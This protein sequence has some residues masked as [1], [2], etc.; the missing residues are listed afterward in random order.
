MT[1][2]RFDPYLMQVGFTLLE[3]LVAMMLFSAV[4]IGLAKGFILQLKSNSNSE[5]RSQAIQ[6]AQVVLDR[7]RTQDPATFPTSGQGASES[8]AVAGRNYTVS[9]RYCVKAA[10]CP[11]STTRHLRA[12][13]NYR[14]AKRYEVDT[15]FT[16]LR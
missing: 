3:V 10:F 12:T 9:V 13:V 16:Q 5:I 15:V 6:A 1:R 8:V 14:G 7:M 4:S 11:T 2:Q